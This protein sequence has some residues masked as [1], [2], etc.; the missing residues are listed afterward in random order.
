MACP[1]CN[2]S[3]MLLRDVCP[4]CDGELRLFDHCADV[5]GDFANICSSLLEDLAA[6]P[7]WE[8]G[9]AWEDH[10]PPPRIAKEK[11]TRLGDELRRCESPVDRIAGDRWMS[12]RLDGTGFS[13]LLRRFRAAGVFGQGYSPEFGEIMC[14]CLVSCMEKFGAVIGYT[15]SDEMTLLVPPRRVIRGTQ[16]V[17]MYGGRVVKLCTLA[18]AHVTALFNFRVLDLA[19]QKGVEW[20]HHDLPTFDCR[21]GSF[22]SA[23]EAVSLILWRA[24]D[25]GVNGVA[26]AV[27]HSKRAGKEV[28]GANTLVKL[29]W[30]KEQGLLPLARHQAHGSLFTKVLRQH[31]GV[32]KA[33]GDSV[34]YSRSVV[35]LVSG[36]DQA[37]NVLRIV[38]HGHVRLPKSIDI[39]AQP[40]DL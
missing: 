24:Y 35:E 10:E 16:E 28:N 13:K 2:G 21:L 4:L 9:L 33:T 26:D 31:E 32:N 39:E 8:T 7:L 37:H 6:A 18:A 5:D 1:V 25:C 30:L 23:D 29:R 19:R 36:E 34:S 22:A 38:G 11:W 27:Y 12:L 14:E 3:G 17:H 40:S 15:Q 20:S